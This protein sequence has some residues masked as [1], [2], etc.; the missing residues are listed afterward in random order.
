MWRFLYGLYFLSL[1]TDASFALTLG[2]RGAKSH[3]TG[4]SESSGRRSFLVGATATLSGLAAASIK[5]AYADSVDI[6]GT[7]VTP[8]NSLMFQYRG[9][10]FGGLDP[11]NIE[12]PSISYSEFV[13][14]L[15]A[16][17]VERVDFLAPDGDVAFCYFKDKTGQ[18]PIR[19]G[20]GYPVEQHDGF[21]SPLFAVRAVK[22]A[23]VPYK[24]IVPALA[25]INN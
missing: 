8:F 12:G 22:N 2:Q 6:R 24:F 4:S 7:R 25:Q 9:G 13:S 16:G 1:F 17:E 3:L 23:G 10:D 20:E 19:I 11:A 21:S 14:K 5:P 15:K 18:S